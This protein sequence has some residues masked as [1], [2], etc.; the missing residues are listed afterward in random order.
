MTR[1]LQGFL[2]EQLGCDRVSLSGKPEV[3]RGAAGIDGTIEAPPVPTLAS[4]LSSTLQ[5]PLVG[6]SS[7][8]H[9]LFSSGA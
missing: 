9:L 8:R 7:R 1:S 2:K 3:D 4:V 5:E 6:F